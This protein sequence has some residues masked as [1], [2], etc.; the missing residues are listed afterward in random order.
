MSFFVHLTPAPV[1]KTPNIQK[2]SLLLAGFFLAMTVAQLFTFEKF[3]DVIEQTWLTGDQS[4]ARLIA[5]LIVT[6][7]VLAL[8]FLLRLKLS[9]A[10]RVLSMILGWLTIAFWLVVVIYQNIQG[11]PIGNSSILGATVALPVGM[12]SIFIFIAL[13]VLAA[14]VSWGMWPL[15]REIK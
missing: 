7:E 14:W 10:M 11:L 15:R 12:W 3:P 5:A 13:G 1:V 8:P 2:V 6:C 4:Q 9:K